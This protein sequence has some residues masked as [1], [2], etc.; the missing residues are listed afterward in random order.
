ML[1]ACG[2]HVSDAPESNARA[3]SRLL[4]CRCLYSPRL[5]MVAQWP[6]AANQIAGVLGA[7]AVFPSLKTDTEQGSLCSENSTHL[8]VIIVASGSW[9]IKKEQTFQPT[10]IKEKQLTQEKV[11][12]GE[13]L[14][15]S[16]THSSTSAGNLI[17][18]SLHVAANIWDLRAPIRIARRWSCLGMSSNE[19]KGE[20]SGRSTSDAGTSNTPPASVTSADHFSQGETTTEQQSAAYEASAA[21]VAEG[22]RLEGNALTIA[23]QFAEAE[24]K[25]TEAIELLRKHGGPK[26]VPHTLYGNRSLVRLEQ[27]KKKSALSDADAALTRDPL[28]LQCFAVTPC[29]NRKACAH[30][31]LGEYIAAHEAY[32][33]ALALDP[34][35]SW[36]KKKAAAAQQLS[37]DY[38]TKSTSIRYCA[39]RNA[40][41]AAQSAL[42]VTQHLQLSLRSCAADVVQHSRRVPAADERAWL[43]AFAALPD[44]RERLHCLASFWN[45]C[46]ESERQAI[47]A[48]FLQ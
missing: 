8:C 7:V 23:S 35:S 40:H 34:T 16:S 21:E 27:G 15:P 37:S 48:R 20:R 24:A 12:R 18:D 33:C 3:A 6:L 43:A 44:A 30:R 38:P 32:M 47:F 22:L 36:L 25:F 29:C 46:S 31:A 26:A 13:A 11:Q 39:V 45:L 14:S 42:P 17:E 2:K 41:I 9:I 5:M 1:H 28:W 10:T 4:P 19:S